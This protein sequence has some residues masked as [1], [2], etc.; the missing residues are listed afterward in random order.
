MHLPPPAQC[1]T[2]RSRAHLGVLLAATLANMV[3]LTALAGS[4]QPTA[5]MGLT[6]LSIT[7]SACSLLAWWRSP[8]GVLGWSGNQWSWGT[9]DRQ[10]LLELHWALD[11]QFAALVRFQPSLP[12]G[13]RRWFWLERGRQNAL[14]WTAMRRALVA[15]QR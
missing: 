3:L 8:V 12:G 6:G 10:L 2:G 15:G 11:F 9:L 4:V 5:W 13:R 7:L 14:G 1:S